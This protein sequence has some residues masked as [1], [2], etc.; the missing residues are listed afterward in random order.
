MPNP[1]SASPTDSGAAA[2][3]DTAERRLGGLTEPHDDA[4]SDELGLPPLLTLAEV[5]RLF[6]RSAR[7]LRDWTKAQ[8]IKVAKIGRAKFVKREEVLRLLGGE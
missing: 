6:R 7:T 8:E 4:P 3:G 2:G 5:A 1:R